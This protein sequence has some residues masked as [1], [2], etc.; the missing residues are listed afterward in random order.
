KARAAFERVSELEKI[1]TDNDVIVRRAQASLADDAERHKRLQQEAA[2]ARQRLE[3][4]NAELRRSLEQSEAA[5][6]RSLEERESALY[7]QLA[8]RES[9][10]ARRTQEIET[11]MAR[12]SSEY[13]A[14]REELE[15]LKT[16][17]ERSVTELIKKAKG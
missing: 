2:E 12:A 3:E 9:A 8:E 5:S 17:V 15:R 14:R 1:L 16:E 6:K 13:R 10:L 7:G 11:A 4:E